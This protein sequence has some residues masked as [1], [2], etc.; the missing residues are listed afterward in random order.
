MEV[1][2]N[3]AVKAGT[4]NGN[5]PHAAPVPDA[6]FPYAVFDDEFAAGGFVYDDYLD[7]VVPEDP[8]PGGEYPDGVFPEDPF[9]ELLDNPFLELRSKDP[10]FA[11]AS[12]A[13]GAAPTPKLSLDDSLAGTQGSL[14]AT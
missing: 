5:A 3:S 8:F 11:D 13:G 12:S 10:L 1:P 6:L 14:K 9:P 4:P 2:G 7:E